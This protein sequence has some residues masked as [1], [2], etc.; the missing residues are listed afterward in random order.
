MNL[1]IINGIELS[2]EESRSISISPTFP[3]PKCVRKQAANSSTPNIPNTHPIP[4]EKRELI[5]HHLTPV[6]HRPYHP[7]PTTHYPSPTPQAHGLL[8]NKTYRT[9]E[10]RG[11]LPGF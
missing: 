9:P 7:S 8:C 5:T 3:I 1:L 11:C 4:P 2:E 6:I 10:E